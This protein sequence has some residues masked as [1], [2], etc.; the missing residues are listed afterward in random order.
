MPSYP[1]VNIHQ[2]I[3]PAAMAELGDLL[4]TL[5]SSDDR[6]WTTRIVLPMLLDRGLTVGSMGGHGPIRYDV[7][8]HE[9]GRRVRF[10]FAPGSPLIGWHQFD[11][12]EVSQARPPLA[13]PGIYLC[14]AGTFGDTPH[15]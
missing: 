10:Q 4:E 9:P 11:V 1:I 7:I 8:A 12:V 13:N 14:R 3:I 2:R 5:A 6:I 15:H